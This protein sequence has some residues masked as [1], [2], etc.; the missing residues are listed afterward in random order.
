MLF[1]RWI[2]KWP[3]GRGFFLP[4]E[5]DTVE[6]DILEEDTPADIVVVGDTV[7]VGSP[8]GK[9]GSGLPEK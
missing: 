5:E 9:E 7:E 6:E 2:R 3:C 8:V 1:S 4:A